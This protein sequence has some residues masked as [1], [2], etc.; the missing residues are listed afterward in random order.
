LSTISTKLAFS[1]PAKE[2][3]PLSSTTGGPVVV[4]NAYAK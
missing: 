1:P 2:A 3:N 4:A